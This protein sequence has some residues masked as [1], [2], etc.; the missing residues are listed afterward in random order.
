[1]QEILLSH[2]HKSQYSSVVTRGNHCLNVGRIG[3]FEEFLPLKS[4]LNIR[5]WSKGL[6]KKS[7]RT[8]AIIDAVLFLIAKVFQLLSI[9]IITGAARAVA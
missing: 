5:T 3:S 6:N 2:F 9:Q 7:K 4:L 8:D 1:M